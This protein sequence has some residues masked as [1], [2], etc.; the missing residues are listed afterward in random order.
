MSVPFFFQ[1]S[2]GLLSG[3]SMKNEGAQK[4]QTHLPAET[5]RRWA[6]QLLLVGFLLGWLCR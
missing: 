3:C 2:N 1:G 4:K 5:A 6:F